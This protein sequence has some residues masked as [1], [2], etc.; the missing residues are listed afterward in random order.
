MLWLSLAGADGHLEHPGELILKHHAVGAGRS[1]D[2]SSESGHGQT[3]D[4]F[5]VSP[6]SS[7][8]FPQGWFLGRVIRSLS[9]Q[10]SKDCGL[11]LVR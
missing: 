9:R 1:H 2:P 8:S 11:Q 7:G 4:S 3:P 10:P 6:I 5:A